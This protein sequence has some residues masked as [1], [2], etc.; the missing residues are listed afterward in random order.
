MCAVTWKIVSFAIHIQKVEIYTIP[1]NHRIYTN[2]FFFREKINP[3]KIDIEA[4]K[5]YNEIQVCDYNNLKAGKDFMLSNGE[6]IDN[7][8]LT[9]NPANPLSYAYCSDTSYK[10]EICK[11]IENCDLLYHESTFLSDKEDLAKKTK[12]STAK[13]AAKIARASNAGQ[14]ILGHYSSRYNDISLFKKEAE[15]IF[16]SVIL[17]DAGKKISI[18]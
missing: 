4:V 13:Q 5:K 6:I 15:E 16:V 9:K 12:H 18:D 11:V 10:P 8:S 14:L 17:A 7:K 2:G 3:R 1:L